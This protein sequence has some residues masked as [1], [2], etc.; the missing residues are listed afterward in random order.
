LISSINGT[1]KMFNPIRIFL[2]KED[3]PTSPQFNLLQYLICM[4]GAGKN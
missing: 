2:K 1:F 3:D 4:D